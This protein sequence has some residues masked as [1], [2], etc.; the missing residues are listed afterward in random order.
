MSDVFHSTA[1]LLRGG[2]AKTVT[3]AIILAAGKSTRMGKNKNK[4]MMTVNGIP[5]L[6][7]TMMAYQDS[8]LIRDIIVVTRKEEFADVLA[9]AKQ[10]GIKKLKKVVTGGNSRQQSAKNGFLHLDADVRYVA[11]ADGARCLTTADMIN[12]VCMR[13]YRYQAASA[14][15]QISSSI[16][17]ASI[18]GTV[19][20]S[21]DRR[22]LWE[23]Q[24]PQVFHTSLY[25]A[26]LYKADNDKVDVTD[27][28]ALIEHLGYQIKLVECG[29]TN[30]KITTPEDISFARAILA[31]R[32]KK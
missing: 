1:R 18:M 11:I 20:G 12:R 15:H 24:T 6:A 28:N 5:V 14:A 19:M 31:A 25:N 2:D 4:Q 27:D 23:A 17:R 30:I 16:K 26:A 3:A 29:M 10:Y 7:H 32:K 13:A 9:L 22:G 21:V 8:S